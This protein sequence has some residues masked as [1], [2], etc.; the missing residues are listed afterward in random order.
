[1]QSVAVNGGSAQRSEV[2]SLTVTFSAQVTIAGNPFTLT[3]IGGGAVGVVMGTPMLDQGRTVVTLTVTGSAEI[4]PQSVL[5]GGSASLADGRYQLSIANGAITG[6]GG[7]LDGDGN[8]T[9]GGGYVSPQD[10]AGS[11]AGR[12]FGLYRLFGDADGN[13]VVDLV[14]L[15]ALRAAFNAGVGD[16]AYVDF[17]D[18][19]H[20]GTV[21]LVDLGAFR[22]RFNATVF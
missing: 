15:G 4:D 14:D 3:R 1:V 2:R 10:S 6:A 16:P 21:D 22:T 8:G 18:A 20:N 11:G 9:A 17:L 12:F 13:G 19:D 7:A 5:N